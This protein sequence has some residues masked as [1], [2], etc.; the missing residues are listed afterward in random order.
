MLIKEL[1]AYSALYPRFLIPIGD[2]LDFLRFLFKSKVERY[3]SFYELFIRGS[4]Y[5]CALGTFEGELCF[6]LGLLADML[7]ACFFKTLISFKISTN[8]IY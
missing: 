3:L 8:C 7:R 2:N 6:F 5:K 1:F 4:T